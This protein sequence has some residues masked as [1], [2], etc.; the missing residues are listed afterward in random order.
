MFGMSFPSLT[1]SS[2][3]F[4]APPIPSGPPYHGKK[5]G[6]KC[7]INDTRN[8]F[9]LWLYGVEHMVKYHSDSER[10]NLLPPY[11]LLFPINSKDSFICIIPQTG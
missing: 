5:K 9:Y 10:R 2:V 4:K 7:L 11:G 8:T 3:R 1:R 6:K